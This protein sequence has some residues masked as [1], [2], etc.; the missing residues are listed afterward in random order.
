[1]NGLAFAYTHKRS[2]KSNCVFTSLAQL[3]IFSVHSHL[4]FSTSAFNCLCILLTSSWP[5]FLSLF[6][7]VHTVTYARTCHLSFA[8]IDS[9]TIPVHSVSVHRCSMRRT[10]RLYN[11]FCRSLAATCLTFSVTRKAGKEGWQTRFARCW[12]GEDAGVQSH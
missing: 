9:Y 6:G 8:L 2:P 12:K 5:I 3:S 7:P 1:M 4:L 10:F 11:F